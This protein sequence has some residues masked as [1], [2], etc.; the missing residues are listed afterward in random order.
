MKA[1]RLLSL[2]VGVLA[3]VAVGSMVVSRLSWKDV[4]ALWFTARPGYLAWGFCAYFLANVLRSW[5][6]RALTGG[7]IST[8]IM[9]RTVMVQNILNTFLPLRAGEVS[10]L[11]MVHKSGV[12]KVGDNVGS[13]LGA[14][15]LDLLGRARRHDHRPRHL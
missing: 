4:S 11:Y 6:F 7:Q 10:Y 2:L 3:S 1:R 12:V 5:R 13:L 14:R 8:R 9:L 15:V